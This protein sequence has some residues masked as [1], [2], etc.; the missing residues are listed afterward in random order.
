M[1]VNIV[2]SLALLLVIFNIHFGIIVAKRYHS[3]FGII[4]WS[5]AL[6]L[7]I[8]VLQKICDINSF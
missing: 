5:M 7:L 8:S 3:F 4:N 6:I 1:L 2:L